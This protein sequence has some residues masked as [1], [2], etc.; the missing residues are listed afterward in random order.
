VI[1]AG[2]T[3]DRHCECKCWIPILKNFLT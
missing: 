2:H 3:P 1:E